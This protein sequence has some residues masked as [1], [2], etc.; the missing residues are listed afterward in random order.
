MGRGEKDYMKTLIIDW[1]D[2][3]SSD[4]LNGIAKCQTI[5]FLIKETDEYVAIAQNRDTGKNFCPFGEIICIPK[6]AIT[7]K[8]IIKQ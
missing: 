3:A 7:K 4:S 6:V 2:S 8:R 5:G 1:V